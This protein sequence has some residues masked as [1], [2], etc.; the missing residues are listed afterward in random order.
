MFLKKYFDI[1]NNSDNLEMRKDMSL[2]NLSR[3][4]SLAYV[5]I[6]LESILI[7]SDVTANFLQIDARFKFDFY[8]FAYLIFILINIIFI[9]FAEKLKQ[10]STSDKFN[11][12]TSENIIIVYMTLIMSWGSVMS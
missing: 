8:L 12:K 10:I 5:T 6:I 11:I 4:R 2:I 3:A 9:L 1:T 7:I